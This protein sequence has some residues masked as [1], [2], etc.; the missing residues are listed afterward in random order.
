[1]RPRRQ[2]DARRGPEARR[3][4][5][6]PYQLPVNDDRAGPDETDAAD[7][8]RRDAAGVETQ[9]V[10]GRQK[11]LESVLR[12]NH[13]QRAAQRHQEMSAETR[14]L[15]PVFP[16]EAD[17]RSAKARHTQPHDKIP[18]HLHKH[19][20]LRPAKIIHKIPA[21]L[22]ERSPAA[23]SSS[24]KHDR[25]RVPGPSKSTGK[26]RPPQDRTAASPGK[27]SRPPESVVTTPNVRKNPGLRRIFGGKVAL[28]EKFRTFAGYV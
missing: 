24:A 20:G 23:A 8:L 16:V 22:R 3:G 26:T 6:P 27:A 11:I 21:F 2:A 12:D 28:W 10:V 14:I 13:N 19:S 7:H 18:F 4:G 5:Q 15:N 1:M 17:D 25:R 9:P